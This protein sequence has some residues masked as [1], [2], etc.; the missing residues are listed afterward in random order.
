MNLMSRSNE[1]P[2]PESKVEEVKEHQAPSGNEEALAKQLGVPDEMYEDWC[3]GF[4]EESAEH[5]DISP[6]IIGKLAYEHIQ[7]DPEYY[8]EEEETEGNE[9]LGESPEAPSREN[10]FKTGKVKRVNKMA[11]AVEQ[12][13]EGGE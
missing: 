11:K 5:S 9:E 8:S 10:Q 4:K 7:K 2:L 6:E 1:V 3:L 13:Y 12:M